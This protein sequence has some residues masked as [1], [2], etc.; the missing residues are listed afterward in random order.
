M[1]HIFNMFPRWKEVITTEHDLQDLHLSDRV[2]SAHRRLRPQV[3]FFEARCCLRLS[4]LKFR[5]LFWITTVKS[6][7]SWM[8]A[9]CLNVSLLILNLAP[10]NF[11]RNKK[12]MQPR[13][14][15]KASHEQRSKPSF[16]ETDG[17]IGIL[18]LAYMSNPHVLGH[19]LSSPISN[20]T[21]KVLNTALISLFGDSKKKEHPY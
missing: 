18:I 11:L 8:W 9:F 14:P 1:L 13:K 3:F 21:T 15:R 12:R 16:H 20:M 6:W 17:F 4:C 2:I 5:Y 10:Q 7:N 19:Y